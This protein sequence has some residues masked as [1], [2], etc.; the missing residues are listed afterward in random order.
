[1]RMA[2]ILCALALGGC[3][4]NSGPG[5]VYSDHE[6]CLNASQGGTYTYDQCRTDRK[7]AHAELTRSAVTPTYN[8]PYPA[9]TSP[10]TQAILQ[11]RRS[12]MLF[13]GGLQMWQMSRPTYHIPQRQ[14]FTC[15]Q[16]GVFTNCY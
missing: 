12:E 16:Q 10:D 15:V 8:N 6:F 1:M 4:T 14:G 13:N 3:V 9:G 5:L 2:L 7:A 11:Q